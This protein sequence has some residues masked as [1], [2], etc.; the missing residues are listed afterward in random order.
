MNEKELHKDIICKVKEYYT[1]THAS[2]QRKKNKIPFAARVFDEDELVNLVD[3]SL[4]FWLTA[5]KYAKRFETE[6]ANFMEV[7]YCHLVNSGSS[8]NLVAISAL[9]S[10]KLGERQLRKGD[11]VITVAASFPT[12]VNPIV[13]NGLVPVFVDVEIPSYNIDVTR[14]NMALSPKTRAIMIAHTFGNPFN[15]ET[16]I[17]FVR[18]HNLY[19]IE[20]CCDAVG[21]TYKDQVVGSFA[22]ISTVSFYPAHHMTMGEGGAVLTS[23]KELSKIIKSFRDWGRDC[24]C[25]PGV[26][27]TCNRRFDRQFGSLPYGYDHKYIY[28]H[29]GYNLKAT[30]LQAAIGL[31]QLKKL[32]FFIA[33]RRENFVSIL[34]ELKQYE[35][36]IILPEAEPLSNPSWFCFPI[37]VKENNKFSRNQLTAFLENNGIM[38]RLLFAGNLTRQPAYETVAYRVAGPLDNTD[39]IMNDTFF[40]GLYPGISKNEIRHISQVF[41]KYFNSLNTLEGEGI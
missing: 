10:P 6:F 34:N 13:Q 4:E 23:D 12:T 29:I 33:K 17:A 1:L 35:K 28:S 15:L 7:K 14:L 20:D 30:D 38:T 2:E 39:R 9:T 27:N 21:S 8:A 36:F 40:I 5:G 32:N 25:D 24:Y 16:V 22:D 37:T 41:K 3:A 31:A 19:L 26:D 18:K 11:E